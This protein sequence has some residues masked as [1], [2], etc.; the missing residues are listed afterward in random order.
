M[1]TNRRGR[2]ERNQ[3]IMEE[4]EIYEL[5]NITTGRRKRKLPVSSLKRKE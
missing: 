3:M 4:K 1:L 5:E 2:K